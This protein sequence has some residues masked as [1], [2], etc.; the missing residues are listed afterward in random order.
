MVKQDTK[1]K[2]NQ[3]PKFIVK[4]WNT[5]VNEGGKTIQELAVLNGPK[6]GKATAIMAG[7]KKKNNVA[8]AKILSLE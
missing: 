1:K 3:P 5:S 7:E 8:V 2:K 6:D 4:Q